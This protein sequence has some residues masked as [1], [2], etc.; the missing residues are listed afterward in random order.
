MNL[1][2]IKS[3]QSK[4][5]EGT[6]KVLQMNRMDSKFLIPIE[7]LP[8]ILDTIRADYYIL[9]NDGNPV[10]KYLTVY[11]EEPH[12]GLDTSH[13]NG[14]SNAYKVRK[15]VYLD[16][17]IGFLEVE[18]INN[19]GKTITKRVLSNLDLMHLSTT[20]VNF[21]TDKLLIDPLSL[22]AIITNQ[23]LRITL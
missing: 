23:F 16:F 3:F 14:K 19:K 7:R 4:A 10:M 18:F 15:R 5:L 11:F 6:P 8:E 9:E 21:L 17:G 12:N 2:I 1:A 13:Y 22:Q 20:D